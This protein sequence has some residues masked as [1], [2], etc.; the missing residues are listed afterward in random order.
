MRVASV[1]TVCICTSFAVA[2]AYYS[3]MTCLVINSLFPCL[4]SHNRETKFTEV[5]KDVD[6]YICINSSSLLNSSTDFEISILSDNDLNTPLRYN[7]V[8]LVT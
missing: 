1:L 8:L 6:C 3:S 5:Y 2:T 7:A 4:F